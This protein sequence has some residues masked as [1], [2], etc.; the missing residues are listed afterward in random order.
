MS[1]HVLDKRNKYTAALAVSH[2]DP[3]NGPKTKEHLWKWINTEQINIS[4]LPLSVFLASYFSLLINPISPCSVSLLFTSISTLCLCLSLYFKRTNVSCS[5]CSTTLVFC[6]QFSQE[7]AV[8]A[9]SYHTAIWQR[10]HREREKRLK[11]I[12]EMRKMSDTARK[13]E[14]DRPAWLS[15][16]DIICFGI[17][18]LNS[19][20]CAT[21]RR[22]DFAFVWLLQSAKEET[23]QLLE[24]LKT[25]PVLLHQNNEWALI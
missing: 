20:C 4:V 24:L 25:A 18:S 5:H 16:S 8:S 12:K 10:A 21:R 2:N 3:I 14:F 9:S 19:N 13:Q 1:T 22:T 6:S 15:S 17:G 23:I 11:E 7:P